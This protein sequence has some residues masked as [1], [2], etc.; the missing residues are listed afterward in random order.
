MNTEILYRNNIF[1]IPIGS[2]LEAEDE[3][4]C[5]VYS[6][7]AGKM[8]VADKE[9]LEELLGDE[10]TFTGVS[11]EIELE[12]SCDAAGQ[13]LA[14]ATVTGIY[15]ID[16]DVSLQ[17]WLVEDGIVGAQLSQEGIDYDYVHNHVLRGAINGTWGESVGTISAGN[18]IERSYTYDIGG[19][20]AENCKVV[21]FVYETAS[22]GNV[23]QAAEVAL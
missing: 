13:L 15:T 7:L 23:L 11:N 18:S 16:Y 4:Y 12:A 14:K 17:L 8:L 9:G 22:R 1:L 10:L 2:Y 19:C 3:A 20:V 5:L 6:P 21:A